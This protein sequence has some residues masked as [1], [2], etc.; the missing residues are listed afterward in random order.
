MAVISRR[1]LYCQAAFAFNEGQDRADYEK[2]LPRLKKY[3]GLINYIS[4]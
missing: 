4:Q 2:A 1:L 3:Y